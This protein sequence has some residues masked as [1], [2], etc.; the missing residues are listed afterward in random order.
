MTDVAVE[1]GHITEVPVHFDDLDALGVLHNARYAVL[2]ERAELAQ[3]RVT[4]MRTSGTS[5]TSMQRSVA[6]GEKDVSEFRVFRPDLVPGLAQTGEYARAVLTAVH[7]VSAS[8][9]PEAQEASLSA[10]LA[11]RVQRQGVLA[12][13]HRRFAFV[14]AEAVLAHAV[15]GPEC[16]LEQIRR[17]RTVAAQP[18]VSLK[19]IPADA[20]WSLPYIHGFELL[21]DRSVVID[22]FNASLIANGAQDVT[23]YR[24]VFDRLDAV[25]TD[26][27]GPI[28]DRYRRHYL[29]RVE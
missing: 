4:D 22:V 2:V 28:L 1:Y 3:N 29:D 18:N 15:G 26:E 14:I 25:A 27:I 11:A 8:A 20:P 13:P 19:I 5:L 21:D 7:E 24:Y 17:L 9:Y 6:R 10:A 12:E 16:M 23:L